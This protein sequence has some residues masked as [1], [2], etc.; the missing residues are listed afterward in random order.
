MWLGNRSGSIIRNESDIAIV[1]RGQGVVDE[2]GDTCI[3]IIVMRPW[4]I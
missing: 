3:I 2:R 4:G 1:N